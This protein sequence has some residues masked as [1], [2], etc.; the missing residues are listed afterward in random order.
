MA[1]TVAAIE[2]LS[3]AAAG[4][5]FADKH[6]RKKTLAREIVFRDAS[7]MTVPVSFPGQADEKIHLLLEC[8]RTWNPHRALGASDIGDL[9]VEIK[10][11][12]GGEWKKP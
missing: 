3:A 9:G 2:G 12:T 6:H 5:Y 1:T 11:P 10:G 4:L 8:E 7:W